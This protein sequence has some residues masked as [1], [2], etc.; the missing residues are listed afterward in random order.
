MVGDKC[1]TVY[2]IP[3]FCQK[4]GLLLSYALGDEVKLPAEEIDPTS[5]HGKNGLGI[6]GSEVEG[7]MLLHSIAKGKKGQMFTLTH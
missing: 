4:R 3:V 2:E 1:Q 7:A 5:I 6:D